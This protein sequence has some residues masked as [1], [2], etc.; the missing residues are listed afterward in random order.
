MDFLKIFI[1]FWLFSILGWIIEM[2]YCSIYDRVIVNRGFLIGPYC[3]IYGFGAVIMLL[4]SGFDNVLIIFVLSLLLCSILE[5]ITS[6]IME[7]MFRVRWWD[8]SNEKCNINGRVCLKNALAFGFLGVIFVKYL[9][10]FFMNKI[11]GIPDNTIKI[12]ALVVLIITLID[13]IVS[14]KVMNSIKEIINK[15]IK[16]YKNIDATS[17]I[18]KLIKTKFKKMNI[19]EK[20]IFSIYH[21]IE[22]RINYKTKY[23]VLLIY[24]L[25]GIILGLLFSFVFKLG[26]KKIVIP[27]TILLSIIIGIIILKRGNKNV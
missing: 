7:K 18:K 20:R 2:I 14:F 8:Y 27:I 19:F 15:N 12:I 6:F 13:I 16:D 21:L 24:L 1:L 3:P 17:N 22:S 11:N 4:L 5:Y 25:L 26:D 10:P 9:N 23:G